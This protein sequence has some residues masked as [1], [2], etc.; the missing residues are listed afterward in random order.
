M[1]KYLR[2]KSH[3]WDTQFDNLYLGKENISKKFDFKQTEE[4]D[5]GE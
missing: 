3:N 1:N 2:T 4:K 5:S